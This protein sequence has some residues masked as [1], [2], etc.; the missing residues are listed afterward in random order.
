MVKAIKWPFERRQKRKKKKKKKPEG[1]KY[2][3]QRA[4]IGKG[5]SVF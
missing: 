4:I 3:Q 5:A 1:T 2:K